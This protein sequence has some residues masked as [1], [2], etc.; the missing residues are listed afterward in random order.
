M[1][2]RTTETQFPGQAASARVRMTYT[3]F[4]DESKMTGFLW[5]LLFGMSLA[6]L[7][8]GMDYQ[9]SSFALPGIIKEFK[10][11]SAQAGLI[12]SMSNIGLLIGAVFF[13]AL[14]EGIG[15]KVIFQWVLLDYAFG[16]FLCAIAPSYN[17]LL[18]GRFIA[19]LGIGAQFPIVMS[20]LAEYSP[21]RLR[22][23]LVPIGPIF[24]AV[25]WIVI[26]F[27]SLWLIPHYGWRAVF[28]VGL[29][30]AAMAIFVRF[31]MPESIRFLLA[32]GRVEEAGRIAN[33]L[34]RRAGRTDIELVPPPVEHRTKLTA[35]QKVGYLG[36]S[37]RVMF[38]LSFFFF[39]HFLQT[40]GLGAWLPTVFMRQGFAMNKSFA[41][42]M[43]IYAATP[44]SLVIAIWWQERVNRKWALFG[45]IWGAAIFFII[46][47]MS[48]Q[49]H[50]PAYVMVGSQVVQ[51]L[52]SGGVAGILY[53][54]SAELFPTQV[55]TLG[56][57]IVNALGRLGAV[58]GP[59]FLGMF[60]HLST[61]M[62]NIMY[63]FA[64]PPI[65]GAIVIVIG[66]K[67]D[68]RQKT[69]E[70]IAVQQGTAR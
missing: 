21:K 37:S 70:E 59:L 65:L 11:N 13:P 48:F 32:H 26:G 12:P 29:L 47:G 24:Y 5:L 50:W 58:L 67:G 69:L 43:M 51:L 16:T 1:R 60:L 15:R 14:C 40:F 27:L 28:W 54:M 49:Y 9:C 44:V 68:Q 66:I 31:F 39:C 10:I 52:F 36:A 57:G 17:V 46:F 42:S 55:R 63:M 18:I 35:G 62:A 30:P 56:M 8:D 3:E 53:T 61:S 25:G 38:A 19:G 34:A 7:L 23:I 6:Q 33:D 2:E 22:H 45:Q 20:I 41:F 64:I 4:L